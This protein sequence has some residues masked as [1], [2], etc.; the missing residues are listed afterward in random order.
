MDKLRIQIVNYKTRSYLLDCL[1]SLVVDLKSFANRYSIAILDNASGEDLSDIPGA[2]PGSNIQT[3]QNDKNLG[4]GA[5][6]NLLAGK[7]EAEYLLLLNPDTKIIEAD[8]VKR[9]VNS[10]TEFDA[11]VLGP[12][13]VTHKGKTQ[14]WDH[15]ELHGWRARLANSC[16]GSYW[17]EHARAVEAAWISG[18]VSLIN[19]QWFDELGGFDE[20]FFLY[21]EEEE[22]CLRLRQKGGRVIYDPTI[23]MFHHGGAVAKRSEHFKKS[24]DYYLSKHFSHRPGYRFL[25]LFY[26]KIIPL[27]LLRLFD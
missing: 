22:L 13:L 6:H 10:I 11:Q 3:F 21:A 7:G 1:T 16:G 23:T 25:R 24:M 9:L 17:R 15:S 4:F 18:A 2:F 27:K 19:K 14:W 8:T 26:N 20:N 5:G 12:R